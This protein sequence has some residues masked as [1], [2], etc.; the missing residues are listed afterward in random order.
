[1]FADYALLD[2]D[3]KVIAIVEAKK[4]ERSARD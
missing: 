4:F 2:T 1:L 3:N